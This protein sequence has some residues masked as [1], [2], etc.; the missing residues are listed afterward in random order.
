MDQKKINERIAMAMLRQCALV[1]EHC[2]RL[3]KEVTSCELKFNEVR[4][5][6]GDYK[7]WKKC[8]IGMI[9]LDLDKCEYQ[10]VFIR[11]MQA[12]KGVEGFRFEGRW[13]M[14]KM[15]FQTSDTDPHMGFGCSYPVDSVF[16][17]VYD[18]CTN[19]GC[20]SLLNKAVFGLDGNGKYARL[21]EVDVTQKSVSK[22]E[23]SGACSSYPECEQTRPE[24]KAQKPR[25]ANAAKKQA[26]KATNPEPCTVSHEPSMAE[27]LRAVLLAQVRRAA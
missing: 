8:P 12:V 17:T 24:V 27:R 16:S 10:D 13:S 2:T 14:I 9:E 18:F 23:E 26:A 25:K 15:F 3:G 21:P 19:N 1:W 5:G 20:Q 4:Y 6:T 22:R 7:M 11:K